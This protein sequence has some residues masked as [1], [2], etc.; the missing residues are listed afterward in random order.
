MLVD[1][2]TYSVFV[3]SKGTYI[4]HLLQIFFFFGGGG[5]KQRIYGEVNLK[6]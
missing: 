3:F 6:M 5:R 2:S 4:L 1:D